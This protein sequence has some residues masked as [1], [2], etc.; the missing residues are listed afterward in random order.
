M[1]NWRLAIFGG[2]LI[3]ALI[4]LVGAL[5]GTEFRGGRPLPPA[6]SFE[7][8]LPAPG[9][10]ASAEWVIDLFRLGIFLGLLLAALAL[11][12]SRNF[13][14]HALY[15]LVTLAVFLCVWYSLSRLPFS[16]QSPVSPAGPSQGGGVGEEG[17]ERA[18]PRAPSWAVYL[19]ALGA[20]LGL[21][22]WLGPRLSVALERKRKKRAIQ[23]VAQEAVAELKKGVPVTDVVLRAWLRMVEILTAR[24]GLGDQPHFTPREFAENMAR[25][26]FRHEAVEILTRLFEEVRYGHKES[27][28]RREE[29]I[30]ALTALERA[31]A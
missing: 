7:M 30:A 27:E 6:G 12:F 23:G 10:P 28:T 26:G 17:E 16:S 22:F 1:K 2:L 11:I 20:A 8:G 9:T 13:R 18:H 31:F 4:F 24:A 5:Q 25:L 19:A 14:K 21:A 29:A 3:L 15:L